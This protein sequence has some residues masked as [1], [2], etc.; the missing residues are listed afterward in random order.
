MRV[1]MSSNTGFTEVG[2]PLIHSFTRPLVRDEVTIWRTSRDVKE[3]LARKLP[4][5]PA[6]PETFKI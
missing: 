1:H 6:S 2:R 3:E 4:S 5:P